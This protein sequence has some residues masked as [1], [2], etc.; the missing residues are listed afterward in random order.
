MAISHQGLKVEGKLWTNILH[1]RI[2]GK[3]EKEDYEIFVPVVEYMIAQHCR[4]RILLELMEFGGWTAGAAWE[5]TKFG[6][7][8]FNDIEKLAFIGDKKWEK[9]M[10]IF[11]KVFTTAQVKF[12]TP[13]EKKDA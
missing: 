9:G 5:D 6:I 10:E 3:F 1:V 2:A 8:H 12:F 4:I 7:E 11:C 13:E